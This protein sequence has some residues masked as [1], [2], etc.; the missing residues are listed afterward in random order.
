MAT[1][2]SLSYLCSQASL[3]TT[4]L[5]F[6]PNKYPADMVG[7]GDGGIKSEPKPVCEGEMHQEASIF[8][9]LPQKQVH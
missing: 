8:G 6:L 4:G 2:C 9:A 7:I 1:E 3:L 5:L